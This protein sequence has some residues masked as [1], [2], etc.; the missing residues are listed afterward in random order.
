[1]SS[2]IDK[3]E[4]KELVNRERST[5]DRRVVHAGITQN[6]EVLMSKMFTRFIKE[7]STILDPMLPEDKKMVMKGFDVLHKAISE[8]LSTD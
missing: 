3:L 8:A 1:M 5:E 4:K 6:G 7:V 2:I